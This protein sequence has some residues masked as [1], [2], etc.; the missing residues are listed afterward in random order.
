MKI[1][2]QVATPDI[3]STPFITAYQG[4]MGEGFKKLRSL[5]Y[6]GVELLLSNPANLDKKKIMDLAQK[7]YL[8]IVMLCTGEVYGQDRLSFMDKDKSTRE[9]ALTRTKEIVELASYLGAQVNIGRLRGQ[10][11]SD[12]PKELSYKWAM[13]SFKS[14]AEY[15]EKF[16]VTIALEAVNIL[17]GNFINTTQEAIEVVKHISSDK[18][19]LM[20][21]VFH[22]HLEDKDMLKSIE[23]STG[24]FSYVHL[25]DSNRRYPGNCKIDFTSII[26][27]L[28]EVGY[29]GALTVE[30]FQIPDQDTAMENSILYL[31]PIIDGLE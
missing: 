11:C 25:T 28:Y 31:K 10:Y 6:D 2:Y 1:C 5:G 22:M 24:Y 3:I 16:N 8:D 7:N 9:N 4:D 19:K 15:G 21:D 17:N 27:K 23:E 26:K 14:I 18:F 13:D 20:L 30:V 12:V 29:N